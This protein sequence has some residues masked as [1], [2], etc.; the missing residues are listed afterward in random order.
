MPASSSRSSIPCSATSKPGSSALITASASGMVLPV[1][2]PQLARRV[3]RLSHSARRRMRHHH[4]RSAQDRHPARRRQPCPAT[5]RGDCAACT[6][7]IGT[8]VHILCL[9][10]C[11]ATI[12]MPQPT[13]ITQFIFGQP[14]SYTAQLGLPRAAQTLH[15]RHV[16]RTCRFS[17]E[18]YRSVFRIL[19]F[20]EA[21]FS[22]SITRY[23]SKP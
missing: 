13:E 16:R 10:D 8:S 18:R 2:S 7:W 15:R 21:G 23:Q 3:G 22:K 1:Q 14:L 6:S 20:A 17:N 11:F 5:S 12:I 9:N 19:L 4:L